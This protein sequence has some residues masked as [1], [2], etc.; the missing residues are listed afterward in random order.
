MRV[1][2][3]KKLAENYVIELIR[4]LML[5]NSYA[6]NNKL[7]DKDNYFIFILSWYG[8]DR[9]SGHPDWDLGLLIEIGEIWLRPQKFGRNHRNLAETREIVTV[10]LADRP[11]YS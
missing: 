4:D 3:I 9:R 6:I 5:I 11:I 2:V 10:D 7:L 1:P 8:R